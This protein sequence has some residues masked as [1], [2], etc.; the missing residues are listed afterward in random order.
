MALKAALL[1]M[2]EPAGNNQPNWK[3]CVCSAG[4]SRTETWIGSAMFNMFSEHLAGK[5]K[6]KNMR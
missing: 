5:L 2:Q 4:E 1:R 3:C 6:H